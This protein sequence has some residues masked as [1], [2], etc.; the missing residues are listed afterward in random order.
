MSWAVA[1]GHPPSRRKRSPIASTAF[2]LSSDI[3]MNPPSPLKIDV[4]INVF[5]K[6]Y[7]TALTLLSLLRHSG[8]SIDKIYFTI[9]APGTEHLYDALFER[10]AGRYITFVPRFHYWVRSSK[11]RGFLFRY[12]IFRQSLRYQYAWESTDKKF[13][14]ITHNDVLYS[15]DVL[16][17]YL[18]AINDNIGVGEVG[19]CWNCPARSANVCSS[20]RYLEYRPTAKEY[21]A[22]ILEHPGSRRKFYSR[23]RHDTAWPLPECRLNEW[24]CMINM[25]KARRITSPYGDCTP[26]GAMHLDIATEWFYDVHRL[27]YTAAH[28]DRKG[29]YAHAWASADGSGHALLFDAERYDA[30]EASARRILEDEYE[31]A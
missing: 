20:E 28:V 19:M 6:P 4:A 1:G 18:Q 23:Y 26:F 8:D 30:A 9:D 21:D 3:N 31:Y 29:L 5:R 13:L 10:L 22:L 24:A 7:Q 12:G 17:T 15:A 25:E 11:Y 14:F 16:A 2:R 27:G